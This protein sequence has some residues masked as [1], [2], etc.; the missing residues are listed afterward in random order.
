M[1]GLSFTAALVEFAKV[2]G[3][4]EEPPFAPRYI[5]PLVLDSPFGQLDPTYQRT[6]AEYVPQMAGQVILMGTQT[7][8]R[9]EVMKELEDCIGEEYVLFRHNKDPRGGREQEIQQFNGKDVETSLFDEAFDGSS[10]LRVT[11]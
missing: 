6:M 2:R 10:F 9:P 3:N 7:Q 4:A 8:I 11:R 5:A 1:L